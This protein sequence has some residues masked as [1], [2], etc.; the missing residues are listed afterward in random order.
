MK[1][2]KV[3]LV[4]GANGFI[5]MK[6]CHSLQK[7]GVRVR[8]LLRKEIEGPWD[9]TVVADLV[10]D[11]LPAEF[12]KNVETIFHLAGKAH[13]VNEIH[14]SL[15][16]YY[17]LNVGGTKK[18]LESA[19]KTGVKNFVFCSSIKA[20]G[21][22]SIIP[23]KE[24][25][26]ELP[27]TYYGKSKLAAEK[28]VLEAFS[29]PH[30]SVFR[31]AM[32]Y[33]PDNP[34]NLDRLIKAISKGLFPP[35]PKIQNKRSMV[36]VDDVVQAALLLADDT[37][38]NRQ[39]YNITDGNYYSTSQIIEWIRIEFGYPLHK[40]STPLSVLKFG[41]KFGDLVSLFIRRKLPLTSDNLDKLISSSAFDSS[42]I[43]NDLGF[44]AKWSL[45]QAF[46]HIINK[47]NEK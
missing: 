34:G 44:R 42:K 32:V 15:D 45:K 43:E 47:L 21:E 22:G 12:F 16:E 28:L 24:S 36:H 18:L 41:A 46:P 27:I 30:T 20:M 8:A 23:Q 10:K 37:Q 35:W 33:G 7:K 17:L 6:L 26:P 2:E 5:G 29:I 11:K 13:A 9:E 25:D 40:F 3:T 38:A 39:V 31:P 1:N 14:S 4:T 19:H